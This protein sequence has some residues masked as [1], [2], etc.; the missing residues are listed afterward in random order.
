MIDNVQEPY[1]VPRKGAWNTDY[2]YYYSGHGF[3]K[4]NYHLYY[5]WTQISMI[6]MND[7][8]DDRMTV[9]I[10]T[11]IKSI[12]IAWLLLRW[13]WHEIVSF[14]TLHYITL[15]YITLQS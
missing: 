12:R 15:H 2:Y 13:T 4:N 5:Q 10:F 3:L 8:I 6:S 11:E 14:N 1:D 7:R 9:Y